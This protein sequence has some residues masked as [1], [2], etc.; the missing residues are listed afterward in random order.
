MAE[1]QLDLNAGDLSTSM[2][3][4]EGLPGQQDPLQ[5]GFSSANNF[6]EQGGG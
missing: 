6:D 5:Q 3:S 1:N 2:N 4:Q